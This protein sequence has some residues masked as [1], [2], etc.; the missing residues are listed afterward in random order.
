MSQML[1]IDLNVAA[2]RSFAR[3]TA[4]LAGALILVTACASDGDKSVS[5]TGA[6]AATPRTAPVTRFDTGPEPG[7]AEHFL[8]NAQERV[9]FDTDRYDLDAEDRSIL[10]RQ[11]AWLQQFPTVDVTVEGHA[12][13]RGTR[14]YNLALGS[15]RANTVRDYLVSL[16]VSPSRIR[17]VS[18]GKERPIAPGSDQRSWNLNRRSVTKVDGGFGS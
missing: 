8:V 10:Q 9:H 15:R 11:A 17:T 7:T 18:F 6:G 4:V 2:M 3:R 12:D 16:G 14:E 5:A 13:E 1:L